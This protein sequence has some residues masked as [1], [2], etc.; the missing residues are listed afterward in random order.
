MT[1]PKSNKFLVL[2]EHENSIFFWI[3]LKS[4]LLF[5][6]FFSSFNCLRIKDCLPLFNFGNGKCFLHF[7][8]PFLPPLLTPTPWDISLCC[9]SLFLISR[10]R[11]DFRI[12]KVLHTCVS[13]VFTNYGDI[14]VFFP[15]ALFESWCTVAREAVYARSYTPLSDNDI[16]PGILQIH[17]VF[18]KFSF[19]IV[20]PDYTTF[21]RQQY[22]K[23]SW[24]KVKKRQSCTKF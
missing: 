8:P 18:C 20:L 13:L 9:L 11:S 7:V 12:S 17:F 1:L 24:T 19:Y 23:H 15:T 6:L 16:R 4:T 2:F 3:Y 21:W 14:T 22:G 5:A 10:L